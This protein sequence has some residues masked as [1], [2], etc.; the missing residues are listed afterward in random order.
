MSTAA[1]S[2]RRARR[3]LR[4]TL[5]GA[6]SAAVLAL[7]CATGAGAEP[8]T[9]LDEQ[10]TDTVGA[11]AGELDQVDTAI[12]GLESEQGIQLWVAY[13]DTFNG[14]SGQDW[15]AQTAELSGLG[16]ND[17]L[18]AVATGAS[19][20]GYSAAE[21]M[22]VSDDELARIMAEEVEPELADGDWADGT[23]VLADSL[24]EPGGSGFGWVWWLLLGALGIALVGFLLTRSRRRAAAPRDVEVQADGSLVPLTPIEDVRSEA[25]AALIDADNSLK[26][27]EQELGFAVAQFGEELTAGFSAA[28]EESRAELSQAFALRQRAEQQA[29]EPSERDAL[30]EVIALCDSADGRLDAQVEKFDT[31]RDLEH[32][33]HDILPGLSAQVEALQARLASATSIAEG[34][35][36][37]HAPEALATVTDNLEQALERV[38]FARESVGVGLRLLAES[39]RVGA[40]SRA[41]AA[42]EA[43]GQAVTLIE[44]V[45]RAPADLEA[46]KAA[47][48]ALIIETE[49]DIAEAQRLGVTPELAVPHQYAMD[50]L[51][52]VRAAVE[53]GVYDPLAAR[54]ALEESDNT[55]EAGLVPVRDAAAARARAEALL[56]TE[57]DA[58]RASIQAA[59]DFI[60]TRRGGIG[61]EAR[62]QLAAARRSYDQAQG[63][64]SDPSAALA[65]MQ[66]ADRLA[67]EA[68]TLAQR[69]ESRYR[70]SQQRAGRST[71]GDMMLGG[72]LMDSMSGGGR[73]TPRTYS[74]GPSSPAGGGR[75]PGS[76]GGTAT[77]ARRSG[78]GR[79]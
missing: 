43:L 55:L 48:A 33:V 46:A 24:A 32:R 52:W 29:G 30:E 76:F 58:A 39:D 49:K 7:A 41:R 9:R 17:M 59:D 23:V 37:D 54:R 73:G 20:Y 22:P 31:L 13:V 27:S 28:L 71:V 45:E 77:R 69:D 14:M 72:I 40:V 68:L 60:R 1:S 36:A 65:G 3:A 66:E 35:R 64:A 19:A 26:T 67:D 8:P 4:R 12:E 79:F 34:L 10:I 57:S 15:A 70:N 75:G 44:A 63:L 5:L 21:P 62:T 47:V 2:M 78:G 11:L 74:A 56:V 51:Q 16:G 38:S 6:S 50:T 42:E 25:A 53:S 61:A 18:L